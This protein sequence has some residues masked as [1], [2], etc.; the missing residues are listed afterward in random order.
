MFFICLF[1]SF[2]AVWVT[3]L[4]DNI[5]TNTMCK[6]IIVLIIIFG[7]PI[8]MGLNVSAVLGIL[9]GIAFFLLAVMIFGCVEQGLMGVVQIVFGVII[10]VEIWVFI[11]ATVVWPDIGEWSNG[12]VVS[13]TLALILNIVFTVLCIVGLMRMRQ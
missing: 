8:I 6:S 3:W 12:Y 13:W 9:V 11:V 10:F 1:C 7:I 5:D 2:R 4:D